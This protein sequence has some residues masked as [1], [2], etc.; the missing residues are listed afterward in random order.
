MKETGI[1]EADGLDGEKSSESGRDSVRSESMSSTGCDVSSS[2]L[3]GAAGELDDNVP[4]ANFHAPSKT[5]FHENGTVG[6]ESS[7]DGVGA[8]GSGSTVGIVDGS[9][10]KTDSLGSVKSA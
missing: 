4:D 7:A 10:A 1:S 9:A 8:S 2:G 3:G 6:V 5:V